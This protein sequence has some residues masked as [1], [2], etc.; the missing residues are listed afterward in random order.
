[1]LYCLL[2]LN[3]FALLV[4]ALLAF[5][6]LALTQSL[7]VEAPTPLYIYNV[8]LFRYIALLC[9]TMIR[10]KTPVHTLTPLPQAQA[11]DTRLRYQQYHQSVEQS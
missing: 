3:A 1:M 5:A 6:L 4:F 10:A 8:I 7:V 11:T 9:Y 2:Q